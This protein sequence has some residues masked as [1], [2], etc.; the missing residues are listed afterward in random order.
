M[1]RRAVRRKSGVW[2]SRK[3]ISVLPRIWIRS[4]WT[5]SGTPARA[6]PGFWI[7]GLEMSLERPS[8]PASTSIRRL[9]KASRNCW[10]VS[11][12]WVS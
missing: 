12:G 11:F 2:R 7:R 4:A 3:E 10:T 6:R 9:G 8:R 1:W 5:N